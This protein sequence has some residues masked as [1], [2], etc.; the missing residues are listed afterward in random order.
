MSELAKTSG[1]SCIINVIGFDLERFYYTY[2]ISV[3]RNGFPLAFW[4]GFF[5]WIFFNSRF[6]IDIYV[7]EIYPCVT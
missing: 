2:R 7:N 3:L 1:E 4:E 6:K 5:L